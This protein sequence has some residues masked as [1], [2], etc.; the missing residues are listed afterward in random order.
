MEKS[1]SQCPLIKECMWFQGEA[2]KIQNTR[3]AL[4]ID[5]KQC[6]PP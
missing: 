6:L 3:I 4:T 2:D 5:K 1:L